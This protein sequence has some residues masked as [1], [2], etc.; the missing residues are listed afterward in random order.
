[1]R[2]VVVFLAGFIAG[3]LFLLAL[4]WSHGSL[5]P[6]RAAAAAVER[7]PAPPQSRATEVPDLIVPV[8]GADVSKVSDTF[9]KTRGGRRHEAVDIM[10]PRGTPVLA[11]GDG[12]IV[13]LFLSRA[14]GNTI[15]QFDPTRTWCYYYA[16]LDRYAAG[17][18]EGMAVR[19]GQTIAY[20]GSTGDAAA[21]AP[22]LH[23]AIFLLGPEGHWWQGTPINPYPI[24]LRHARK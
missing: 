16:H 22:H 21:E 2:A 11:A 12:T 13:K 24:L 23:F 10:A 19:R 6:V 15:Y 17:I 14:G 9:E 5:R 18:Q 7:A 20:A 3:M 4:L 8:A 1:M